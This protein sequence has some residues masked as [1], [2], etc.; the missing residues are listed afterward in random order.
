MKCD[1]YDPD[2][3]KTGNGFFNSFTI[4]MRTYVK[5]PPYS[6]LMVLLLSIHFALA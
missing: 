1:T 4:P 2:Y 3:P 5:L 6:S